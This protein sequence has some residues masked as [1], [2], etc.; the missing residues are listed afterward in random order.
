MKQ[1]NTKLLQIIS[2]IFIIGAIISCSSPNFRHTNS[3]VIDEDSILITSGSKFEIIDD[4]TFILRNN[5]SLISKY[6]LKTGKLLNSFTITDSSKLKKIINHILEYVPK[7]DY[8]IITDVEEAKLKYHVNIFEIPN[9]FYSNGNFYFFTSFLTP[10]NQNHEKYGKIFSLSKEGVL[11]TTDVNFNIKKYQVLNFDF[12]QKVNPG[13]FFDLILYK[14]SIFALNSVMLRNN[15]I[16]SLYN[17]ISSFSYSN[18]DEIVY[19]KN[20]FVKNIYYPKNTRVF[21]GTINPRNAHFNICDNSLYIGLENSIYN[22]NTAKEELNINDSC[23]I[24]DYYI[25]KENNKTLFVSYNKETKKTFLNFIDNN[26]LK[27]EV[28]LINKKIINNCVY[29][30]KIYILT[31]DKE[32]YYVEEYSID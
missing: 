18:K 23:L 2:I 21:N 19:F 4:S 31:K 10:Y 11:I 8:K 25:D 32:N 3:T 24:K 5:K 17:A 28:N 30:N 14:D 7:K 22:V 12:S 29:N 13:I 26:N 27:L 16:D 20:N 15:K 9:C 6:N 1:I